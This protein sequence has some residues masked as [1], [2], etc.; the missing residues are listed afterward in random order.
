MRDRVIGFTIALIVMATAAW[1][2][3]RVMLEGI[4]VRVNDRIVTVSE[5]VDRVGQDL[6]QLPTPPSTEPMSGS[7][8][9][10]RRLGPCRGTPSF[11]SVP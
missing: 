11:W 7:R 9:E 3:E 4:L 5:F 6:A 8:S 2:A 10:S 1:A